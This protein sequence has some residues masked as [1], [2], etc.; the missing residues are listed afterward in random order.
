[1]LTTHTR[2]TVLAAAIALIGILAASALLFS[3]QS[4]AHPTPSATDALAAAT[5]AGGEVAAT[6]NGT[7]ILLATVRQAQIMSQV[8]GGPAQEA[9]NKPGAALDQMIRSELLFQEAARRGLVPADSLVR[10]QVLEQQAAL[11]SDLAGPSADPTMQKVQAQLAGTGF[12]VDEYATSP[13]V[14]SLFQHSMAV[15]ALTNAITADIP[16]DARTQEAIAARL[17]TLYQQLP[18]KADVKILVSR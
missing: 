8:V 10:A 7:P 4:D 5:A 1:M 16:A 2:I 14:F 6:L 12:S 18:D 15:A 11:K 17:G 3:R 13:Q 9:L